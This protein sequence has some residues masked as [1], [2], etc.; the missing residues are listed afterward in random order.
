M[1]HISAFIIFFYNACSSASLIMQAHGVGALNINY[2]VAQSLESFHQHEQLSKEAIKVFAQRVA[3]KGWGIKGDTPS[4]GNCCFWALSAQLDMVAGENITP[5][6]LRKSA[7]NYLLEM[8]E[9]C[10]NLLYIL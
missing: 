3:A 1:L 5:A 6:E 2:A 8:P 9:A 4:D 10:L 7:T